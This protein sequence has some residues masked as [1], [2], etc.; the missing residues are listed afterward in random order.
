[1]KFSSVA[2]EKHPQRGWT[3]CLWEIKPGV[4]DVRQQSKKTNTQENDRAAGRKDHN[5]CARAIYMRDISTYIV[6]CWISDGVK[7]QTV[8]LG[9]YYSI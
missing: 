6:S 4:T 2:V 9:L 7:C 1:M 8:K 5:N 3:V